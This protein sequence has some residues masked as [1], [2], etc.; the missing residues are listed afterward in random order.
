MEE[1]E[2]V[3]YTIRNTKVLRPPRQSLATFGI[4]NIY[5]Y[6]VTELLDRANR[7][8]IREGKVSAERPKIIFPQDPTDIF[9]GF[10]ED[11]REYAQMLLQ[12]SELDY[13]ILEYKFRNELKKI[14]VK[15]G[16]LDSV[17][18]RINEM[19]DRKGG[20]LTA[21]IKGVDDAWQVSL[22]KFIAETT[23]ES[24]H[25]NIMELEDRGFFERRG[26]SF[27]NMREKIE[28]LFRQAERD[29]TKISELAAK[30]NEFGLFKEY[31][32]RFFNLFRGQ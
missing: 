7:I 11:A 17:V 24:S 12:R 4:T 10:G 1:V 16:S 15:S 18:A 14:D 22:M 13:R 29:K 26:Q 31:E 2:K 30:L 3:K 27:R 9:E 20:K 19:L 32:D 28:E 25:I 23:M 21:I 8:R 5:Y 6:L